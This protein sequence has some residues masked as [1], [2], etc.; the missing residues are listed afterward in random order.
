METNA[1]QKLYINK[2]RRQNLQYSYAIEHI[3]ISKAGYEA[4]IFHAASSSLHK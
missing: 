3:R 4:N 1:L 2:K